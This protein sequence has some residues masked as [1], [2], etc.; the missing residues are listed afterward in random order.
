MMVFALVICLGFTAAYADK[1]TSGAT[2]GGSNGIA[3]GYGALELFNST[4]GGN[5]KVTGKT[6][7]SVAE[8][9][10]WVRAIIYYAYSAG[11]GSNANTNSGKGTSWTSVSV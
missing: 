5:D 7:A 3:T 10:N 11:S 4:S 6:K 9:D 8:G 2:S 1:S